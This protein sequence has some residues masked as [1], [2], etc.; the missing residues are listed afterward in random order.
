ML[1]RAY[2]A[3]ELRANM[4][5]NNIKVDIKEMALMTKRSENR[6]MNILS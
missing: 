3:A 1:L 2:R 5:K 6:F 4:L